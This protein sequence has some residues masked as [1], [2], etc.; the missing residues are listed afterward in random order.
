[1]ALS[2]AFAGQAHLDHIAVFMADGRI[3]GKF[4]QGVKADTLNLAD[5]SEASQIGFVT[6]ASEAAEKWGVGTV[7][8]NETEFAKIIADAVAVKEALIAK[9]EEEPKQ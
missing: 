1:M 8:D 7:E 5:F 4:D 9:E 6:F 2:K 3:G